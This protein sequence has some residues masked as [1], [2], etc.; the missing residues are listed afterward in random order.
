MRWPTNTQNH[1]TQKLKEK[2]SFDR[3]ATRDSNYHRSHFYLAPELG[4]C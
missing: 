2:F 3:R 4:S 1:R